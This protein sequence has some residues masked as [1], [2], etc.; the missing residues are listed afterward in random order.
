MSIDKSIP[1]EFRIPLSGRSRPPI[2]ERLEELLIGRLDGLDDGLLD[3]LPI[4]GS[5]VVDPDVG[6]LFDF[7]FSSEGR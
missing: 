2:D 5:T 7:T 4:G 3:A 1:P 6:L